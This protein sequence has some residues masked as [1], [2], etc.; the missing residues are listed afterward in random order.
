MAAACS[1][2]SGADVPGG[3]GGG[4]GGGGGGT[5]EDGGPL[6][7]GSGGSTGCDLTKPFG[8]P[9][10][11]TSLNTAASETAP[12]ISKDGLTLYYSVTTLNGTQAATYVTK[13]PSVDAPW[14]SADI[15]GTTG[16][17][18]RPSNAALTD[19]E[20]TMFEQLYF[21]GDAGTH[22]YS[23]TR[24]TR[25]GTFQPAKELT[26]LNGGVD[27][28]TPFPLGDGTVVYFSSERQG[29]QSRDLF[30]ASRSS[31]TGAFGAPARVTGASSGGI[32]M[33]P[34][35]SADEL[36]LF[37]SS[38]R[39]NNGSY[40]IYVAT[41]ASTNDPWGAGE[42]IAEVNSPNDEHPG[43]LSSDG[44]E[45]YMASTRAG[46]AGMFDLYV[47]RRGR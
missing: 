36:T 11:L 33:Y 10:P 47:A 26:A 35:V 37:Y 27:D 6:A 13:R 14:G 32:D 12:R 9:T 5:S 38:K 2:T 17:P 41:R 28:L 31:P 46:G 3:G 34:A 22:L 7:D 1:G 24:T 8:E 16:L 43:S 40:D 18:G 25:D 45:L 15:V 44:C 30:R 42:P 29:T 39:S 4:D 21:G 20:L 23:A 19:D